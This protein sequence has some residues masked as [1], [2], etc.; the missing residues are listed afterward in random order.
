MHIHDNLVFVGS[1]HS[2]QS[3][4]L[5]KGEHMDKLTTNAIYSN[6]VGAWK[7]TRTSKF[8]KLIIKE[9]PWKIFP[10]KNFGKVLA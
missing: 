9:I 10:W 1:N 8:L 4:T 6:G 2:F 5:G 7:D 3:W